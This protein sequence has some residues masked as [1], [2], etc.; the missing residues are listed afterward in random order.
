MKKLSFLALA[1]LFLIGG[2]AWGQ[3]VPEKQNRE[4][5]QSPEVRALLLAKNNALMGYE[6]QNPIFLITAAQLMIDNPGTAL[7]YKT[8]E[9]PAGDKE[10][11][12]T[13]YKIDLNPEKLL[14]DAILY[15]QGNEMVIEMANNLQ[16]II[17]T[18]V[19]RGAVGGPYLLSRRVNKYST[20]SYTVDFRARQLAEVAIVGDGDTDL[21]LFV[22]DS[23]GNLVAADEDYTDECYVS[24][25]PNF[26]QTYTIVVKNYGSVYNEFLIATN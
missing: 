8:A 3:E 18:T 10:E 15:A 13:D 2:L 6:T 24:W 20:N 17:S 26:T 5:D 4:G 14:E 19:S 23:L 12:K 25:M 21:D 7:E 1:G 22:F 16:K 9:E 11:E